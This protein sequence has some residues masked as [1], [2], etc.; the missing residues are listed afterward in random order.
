MSKGKIAIIFI[1]AALIVLTV[2][3]GVVFYQVPFDYDLGSLHAVDNDVVLLSADDPLNKSDS[4][5][6]AKVKD[7]AISTEDFRVLLLT[8]VHLCEVKQPTKET[9]ERF[10]AWIYAE[11]PDLIVL[12]G[13]T[14]NGL[15][16]RV[17]VEQFRTLMDKFHIYW[18]PVLGNHEGDRS[19]LM[20]S[21]KEVVKI[22]SAS[23][24]CLMESDVKQTADGRTVDG[25]GNYVVSILGADGYIKDSLFMLDNGSKLMKKSE[26]E[27]WGVNKKADTAISTAQVDWY[28]ETYL[29]M[30][31]KNGGELTHMCVIHKPLQE[32]GEAVYLPADTKYG[33]VAD[34]A[35]SYKG[36][37]AGWELVD[38]TLRDTVHC[39]PYR[40]GNLYAALTLNHAKAVFFGHDHV[41][42][43]TLYN[44]N[45]D[46]YLTYIRLTTVKENVPDAEG[47]NILTV[48]ANG[49]Y[50]YRAYKTDGTLDAELF[51]K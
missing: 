22:W 50:D 14:L 20:T 10:T 29:A 33:E 48:K 45:D 15:N 9:I 43:L 30:K 31:E 34:W 23:P 3:C 39:P 21:R 35:F 5:A 4:P 40:D 17:R 38:G 44:P 41:N 28:N 13:D 19:V 37:A 26:Y 2:V 42:D 46:I 24:W 8:D 25:Y 11:K 27:K 1:L 18:A 51:E 47:Y 6:L 36:I 49:G 16:D 32:L 7:G 12:G